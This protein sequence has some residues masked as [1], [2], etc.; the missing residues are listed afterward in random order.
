MGSDKPKQYLPLAGKTVLQH[1]VQVLLQHPQISGAVVA[2]SESDPYWDEHPVDVPGKPLIHASGGDER[3]HSVLNGLNKLLQHAQA[4][5]WVLVH[6]AARPCLRSEDITLLLQTLRQDPV[7]GILAVP[8]NDTIKRSR[9]EDANLIESTLDRRCLWQAQT[10]QMFRIQPLKQ[11]LEQAL[12][13]GYLVTDEASAME[14]AGLSPRLVQGHADN[15]KITR[16]EDLALAQF[17]L[18][19]RERGQ[20]CE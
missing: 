7:G 20:A 8:V 11:A 1:S 4:D 9:G 13:Q 3:C 5:D 10:P 2:V 12:Q 19:Q 17:F 16:P 6:D 18:L 15:I 14:F